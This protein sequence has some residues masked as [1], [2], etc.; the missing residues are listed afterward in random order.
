[1][2]PPKQRE[3]CEQ[4]AGLLG[5]EGAAGGLAQ[6]LLGVGAPLGRGYLAQRLL[7]IAPSS[8]ASCRMRSRIDRQAIRLSWLSLAVSWFCQWRISVGRIVSMG[9]S[10]NQGRTWRR[11]RFSVASSVVGLRSGSVDHTAH[12]W[13]AHRLNGCRPWRRPSRVPR[14]AS[15]R[16]CA[17]RPRASSLVATVL[18]PWEPS[19]SS[20]QTW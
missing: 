1:V 3:P 11:S 2:I 20:H 15:S 14:V 9:R 18:A 8:S 13:S 19:S 5:R 17:I 10:P 7:A 12:H 6:Q 4:A 16:F